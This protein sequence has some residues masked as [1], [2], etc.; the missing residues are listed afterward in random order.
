MA[1][2]HSNR[3]A[4][5]LIPLPVLGREMEH[6]VVSAG[7][8]AINILLCKLGTV[9]IEEAQL[10]GGI[11]GE[12]QYMKDELESMA[13]FLQ[14]LAEGGNRR[15]Q[16]K[17][18]MKQV[19]EVAYDVEDCVDDFTYHLGSTTSGSGLAGLFHRCIRF[20]QT[21]RV[22]RQIAKRI[23][24]LKARATSISDRNSRYL[25]FSSLYKILMPHG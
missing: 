15:K 11:R 10:L 18:W 13:A 2:P 16:V 8:G 24:E 12:L 4:E 20:L 7:G 3:T 22:R 17:I 1:Q 14:D 23:Q 5:A 19:R 21:V 25:H 9:L 6:P